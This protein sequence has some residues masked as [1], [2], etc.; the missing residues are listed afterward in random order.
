MNKKTSA[1]ARE[2]IAKGND[3]KS[4]VRPRVS[5]SPTMSTQTPSFSATDVV[6][7]RDFFPRLT[8][9]SPIFAT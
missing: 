8:Q 4:G 1:K 9:F 3:E 6:P 5:T 7:N 2:I